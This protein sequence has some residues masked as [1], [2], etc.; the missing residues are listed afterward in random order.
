M[1]ELSEVNRIANILTRVALDK[2]IEDVTTTEDAIVYA[3]GITN[4]DFVSRTLIFGMSN[5]L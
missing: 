4:L 2:T 1:P 5:L 3:D